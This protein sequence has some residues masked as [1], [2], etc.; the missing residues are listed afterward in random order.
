M[1]HPNTRNTTLPSDPYSEE[2]SHHRIIIYRNFV[3]HRSYNP[4]KV[5]MPERSVHL[6]LYPNDPNYLFDQSD[7]NSNNSR[8]SITDEMKYFHKLFEDKCKIVVKM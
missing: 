3:T 5:K 2:G 4:I 1:L 6:L 8:K 7:P